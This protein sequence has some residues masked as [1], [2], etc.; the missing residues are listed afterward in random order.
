MSLSF[1]CLC[2]FFFSF[3]PL[4]KHSKDTQGVARKPRAQSHWPWY[5]EHITMNPNVRISTPQL[6]SR[7]WASPLFCF[8]TVWNTSSS[9]T[10]AYSSTPQNKCKKKK[11]KIASI[12]IS[13]LFVWLWSMCF[14]Y[15][16]KQLSSFSCV[17]LGCVCVCVEIRRT[18]FLRTWTQLSS[19][20]YWKK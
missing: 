14:T 19:R 5:K 15:K 1:F 12:I 2:F 20:R 4:S 9:P 16:K 11:K 18:I 7:M 13:W 10:L 8:S 6:H 3:S 17:S